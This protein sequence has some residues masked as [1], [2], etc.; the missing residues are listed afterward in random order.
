MYR[1]LPYIQRKKTY[2]Y[3]QNEIVICLAVRETLQIV[4]KIK[5]RI[6]QIFL[7]NTSEFYKWTIGLLF[8]Q[9]T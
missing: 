6:S 3:V 2:S 9:S 1:V 5:I 7:R 8:L 4:I